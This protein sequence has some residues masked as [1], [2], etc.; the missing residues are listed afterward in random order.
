MK[1]CQPVVALDGTHLMN[2]NGVLLVATTKDPNNHL[3][4]LGIA[5]VPVENYDN[6]Q[7]FMRHL[8]T[9]GILRADVVILSDRDK[10]LKKHAWMSVLNYLIHFVYGISW[11]IY[12]QPRTCP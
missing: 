5:I 7:W 9:A 6:W 11:R 2:S 3:L 1:L 8:Q 12:D 4:V 10:G